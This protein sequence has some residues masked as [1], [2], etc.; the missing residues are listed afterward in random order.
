MTHTHTNSPPPLPPGPMHIHHNYAQQEFKL[1]F[2]LQ[3]RGTLHQFSFT[4]YSTNKTRNM[5]IYFCYFCLLTMAL[6]ML[7]LIQRKS[8]K[9]KK[10]ICTFYDSFIHLTVK[11]VAGNSEYLPA[12]GIALGYV[13][14]RTLCANPLP[15]CFCHNLCRTCCLFSDVSQSLKKQPDAVVPC[16]HHIHFL[17][18]IWDW[19]SWPMGSVHK[20]APFLCGSLP[21]SV[22]GV[23][24]KD[25]G[26]TQWKKWWISIAVQKNRLKPASLFCW[27]IS[28]LLESI[29]LIIS[30]W[31]N[32]VLE[33]N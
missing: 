15:P 5:K 8:V 29:Y 31:S 10:S 7:H 13:T 6:E 33:E 28:F 18:C 32:I 23:K 9:K 21:V 3:S 17:K 11:K 22:I 12:S 27:T 1:L 19:A 30:P 2:V 26:E 24:G 14:L 25:K 20:S 4:L 16:Q